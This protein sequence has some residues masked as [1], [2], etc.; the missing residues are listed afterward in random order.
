MDY[1]WNIMGIWN[2]CGISL[3]YHENIIGIQ[4]NINGRYL[5]QLQIQPAH[6]SGTAEAAAD[7]VTWDTQKKIDPP[8][9]QCWEV[10]SSGPIFWGL[11]KTHQNPEKFIKF[12]QIPIG[13]WFKSYFI[14]I[15]FRVKQGPSTDLRTH[16]RTHPRHFAGPDAIS[17]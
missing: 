3:E 11:V 6:S 2:K 7:I 8:L 4:W 9:K 13:V 16:P 17:R 1:H 5:P 14:V 10:P 12:H 15:F